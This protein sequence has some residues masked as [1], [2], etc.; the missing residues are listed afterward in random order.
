MLANRGRA[1]TD[2]GGV[3]LIGAG[4][5]LRGRGFRQHCTWRQCDNGMQLNLYEYERL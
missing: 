5:V 4:R 2:R 3:S 1:R